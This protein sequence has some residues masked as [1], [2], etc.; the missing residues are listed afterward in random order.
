MDLLIVAV[1]VVIIFVDSPVRD[2]FFHFFFLSFQLFFLFLSRDIMNTIILF[3]FD[4]G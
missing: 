2:F 1:L 4:W 3:Y